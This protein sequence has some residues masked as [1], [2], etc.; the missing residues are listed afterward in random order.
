[1]RTLLTIILTALAVVAT[2]ACGGDAP[3]TQANGNEVSPSASPTPTEGRPVATPTSYSTTINQLLI[4]GT[5]EANMPQLKPSAS[6]EAGGAQET[7]EGDMPAAANAVVGGDNGASDKPING[8]AQ[9]V[10]A[11]VTPTPEPTAPTPAPRPVGTAPVTAP[12]VPTAEPATQAEE[13]VWHKEFEPVVDTTER[14]VQELFD[15]LRP[16]A[17]QTRVNGI[18]KLKPRKGEKFKVYSSPTEW[19]EFT[20]GPEIGTSLD[21]RVNPTHTRYSHFLFLWMGE[22][23]KVDSRK[24]EYCLGVSKY[25]DWNNPEPVIELLSRDYREMFTRNLYEELGFMGAGDGHIVFKY[26]VSEDSVVQLTPG[27][28]GKKVVGRTFTPIPSGWLRMRGGDG[29]IVT[30]PETREEQICSHE[31]LPNALWSDE[32][33][34]FGIT[35][36]DM[37]TLSDLWYWAPF[38]EE[39]VPAIEQA[40]KDGIYFVYMN[41]HLGN[42][43]VSTCWRVVNADEVPYEPCLSCQYW[44]HYR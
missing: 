5:V 16:F 28:H 30:D 36:D 15:L 41:G 26:Q 20:C 2:F 8:S 14:N 39:N 34:F 33:G 18:R 44:A 23:E 25:V 29:F 31:T 24:R 40:R 11:Q 1:M 35:L 17:D 10:I 6:A 37:R 13:K 12:L 21:P 7:E 19:Q 4:S 22:T 42:G 9:P 38:S 32:R 3:A 43:D 27:P